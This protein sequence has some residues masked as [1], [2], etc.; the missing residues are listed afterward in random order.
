MKM[1]IK[2]PLLL[3]AIK[4]ISFMEVNQNEENYCKFILANLWYISKDGESYDGFIW[5]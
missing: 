5:V 4:S 3:F 2:Y 1:R